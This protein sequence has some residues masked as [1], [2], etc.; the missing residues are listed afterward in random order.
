[1]KQLSF[2]ARSSSGDPC[3][4][5]FT[6]KGNR[7]TAFCTCPA[8]THRKLC[9]HV[10]SL[11]GGDARALYDPAEAQRLAE[12]TGVVKRSGFSE[13]ARSLYE[14]EKRIKEEQSRLGQ[15][16]RDFTRALKSGL[17]LEE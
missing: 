9:Q 14:Q 11:L 2:Q 3:D 1:M 12:L 4:V 13:F 8:G 16:K 6:V 10:L 7:L 5:T 15:L 17:V